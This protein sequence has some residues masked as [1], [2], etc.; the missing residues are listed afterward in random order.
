MPL[1]KIREIVG[2]P[3]HTDAGELALIEVLKEVLR[4]YGFKRRTDGNPRFDLPVGRFPFSIAAYQTR[5]ERQAGTVFSKRTDKGLSVEAIV[6]RDNIK[7]ILENAHNIGIIAD[8]KEHI[9]GDKELEQWFHVVT[10][11]LE[12]FK[13]IIPERLWHIQITEKLNVTNQTD[14]PTWGSYNRFV[15]RLVNAVNASLE[16]E[17]RINGNSI[18][19]AELKTEY[20]NNDIY[21]NRYYVRS[22]RPIEPTLVDQP[23]SCRELVQVITH[24]IFEWIKSVEMNMLLQRVTPDEDWLCFVLSHL[25][26]ICGRL[27][28]KER[29]TSSS[30]HRKC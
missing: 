15:S 9:Y 3:E 19:P 25:H 1:V 6:L 17:Q 27:V 4:S 5:S 10:V 20:K 29:V 7:Y 8:K 12:K 24:I 11:L 21:A 23:L 2:E 30:P 16:Q 28:P 18:I 26:G 14:G 13:G 22:D